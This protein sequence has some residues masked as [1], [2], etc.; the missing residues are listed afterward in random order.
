MLIWSAELQHEA[1]LE[2][3]AHIWIFKQGNWTKLLKTPRRAF[4]ATGPGQ[5]FAHALRDGSKVPRETAFA[6]H[7]MDKDSKLYAK[8]GLVYYRVQGSPRTQPA[9]QP[10]ASRVHRRPG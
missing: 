7:W 4:R 8:N 9:M 10:S 5:P 6:A 3:E 1:D 2:G